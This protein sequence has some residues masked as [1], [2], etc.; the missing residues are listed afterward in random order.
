MRNDWILDVLT[1]L[2]SF[3]EQNGLTASAEQL[4]DACVVVAAELSHVEPQA[5]L[6][7]VGVNDVRIAELSGGH[8]AR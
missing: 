8:T 5:V 3:A 2:R 6:T 4:S 1:D 7:Q